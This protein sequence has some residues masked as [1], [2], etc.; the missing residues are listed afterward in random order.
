MAGEVS[1]A[2]GA[3][4]KAENIVSTK[5]SEFSTA[6]NRLESEL[7]GIGAQWKG[8]AS[9][10]FQRLMQAW[11]EDAKSIINEL[12][13]FETNLRESQSTFTAS[14]EEQAAASS[15]LQGRLNR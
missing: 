3:L 1:A 7:A 12:N 6:V 5:R 2:D 8:T 10:A 11:R 15:R 14:D 4:N 13:T 9:M